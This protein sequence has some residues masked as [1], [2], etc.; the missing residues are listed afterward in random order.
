MV[1]VDQ[2]EDPVLETCGK[3]VE[4]LSDLI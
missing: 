2:L 3:V 1:F 4:L